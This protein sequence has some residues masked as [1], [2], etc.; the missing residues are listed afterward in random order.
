MD[1]T[2]QTQEELYQRVHPALRAKKM[3]L[4]RLG[5]SY[6]KESD[7]WNYLKKSK[8]TKSKNLMLSDIVSD[9]LH[10]DNQKIDRYVKQ[11]WE[12][13]ESTPFYDDEII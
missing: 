10:L 11:E 5:F 9:I 6:I 12:K 7:I 13:Q 3:E 8:W 2:F 4:W 1:I